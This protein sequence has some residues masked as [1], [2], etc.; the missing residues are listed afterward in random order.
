MAYKVLL[1]VTGIVFI[2]IGLIISF[3]L[4]MYIAKEKD[5]YGFFS[6]IITLPLIMLGIYCLR[7]GIKIK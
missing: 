1:I 2:I 7:R 4:I 6:F 5:K 3:G